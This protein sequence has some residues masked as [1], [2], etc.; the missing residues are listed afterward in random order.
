MTA[1]DVILQA[2]RGQTPWS[3]LQDLDVDLE[4]NGASCSI[5][6]PRHLVAVA[7]PADISCGFL[8]Y[9]NDPERLKT[10]AWLVLAASSLIDLDL[11]G[12]ASGD[13][14]LDALWDAAYGVPL[15]QDVLRIARK[16]S[17]EQDSQLKD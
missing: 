6:N 12:H 5:E 3:A 8:N 7:K 11:E 16:V 9:R 2:V 15:S 14:L 17:R 4:I 10:W 1:E 13:V